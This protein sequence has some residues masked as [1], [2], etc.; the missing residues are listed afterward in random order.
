MEHLRC[1]VMQSVDGSNDNKPIASQH[2]WVPN[3]QR[4]RDPEF[5]RI[6]YSCLIVTLHA[7]FLVFV[8]LGGY[9]VSISLAVW[10]LF[11]REVPYGGRAGYGSNPER[12]VVAPRMGCFH[13]FFISSFVRKL[14]KHGRMKKFC[15]SHQEPGWLLP[16][17]LPTLDC[18]SLVF[19][20]CG[21][22]SREHFNEYEPPP[23][24][25]IM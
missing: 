16:G 21:S 2:F 17:H 14:W 3:F 23:L 19:S 1:Q 15:Y 22:P 20:S 10:L 9:V 8:F 18:H 4:F 13:V 25:I 24:C 5:Q 6:W 12:H 11:F 7:V